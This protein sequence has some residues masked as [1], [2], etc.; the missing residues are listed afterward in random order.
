MQSAGRSWD[1]V[2]IARVFRSTVRSS[3]VPLAESAFAMAALVR[4]AM[5]DAGF[6]GPLATT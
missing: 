1:E 2:E 4:L 3:D 5:V 6:D